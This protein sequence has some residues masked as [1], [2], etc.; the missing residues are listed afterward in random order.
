MTDEPKGRVEIILPGE[1]SSAGRM[2]VVTNNSEIKVIK[3]SALQS[4]GVAIGLLVFLFLGFTLLSGAFMMML[5]FAVVAGA[6]AYI[7]GLLGF[8]KSA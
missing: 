2:W 6:G 7:A 8:K 5:L 3:L 4:V 1:E